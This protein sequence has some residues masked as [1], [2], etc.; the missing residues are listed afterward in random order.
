M[1][2]KWG[3]SLCSQLLYQNQHIV[4]IIPKNSPQTLEILPIANVLKEYY[5]VAVLTLVGICNAAVSVLQKI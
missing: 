5:V 1:I 3:K 2:N 4:S